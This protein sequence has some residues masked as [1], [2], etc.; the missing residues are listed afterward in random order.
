MSGELRIGDVDTLLPLRVPHRRFVLT[1]ESEPETSFTRGSLRA[2]D[3]G[4]S[5][6][7]QSNAALF[8]AL[9]EFVDQ[10]M[11]LDAGEPQP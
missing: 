1:L 5:Y 9:V 10:Q 6:P 4:V 3:D 8:D 2:L 11:G 7:I